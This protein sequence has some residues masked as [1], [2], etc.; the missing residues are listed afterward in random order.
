RDVLDPALL[1]PG[2]LGDLIVEIP[3]PDRSAAAAIF[4]KHLPAD[5][6]YAGEDGHTDG[7]S[8]RRAA[9]IDTAVSR[10]YAPNGEGDIAAVMFRDGTRR[11]IQSRD[12]IT[13]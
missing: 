9:V 7:H 10:L 12:V 8:A 4:A 13:G 1:R 2:R 5:I 6:P 11:A 3:R